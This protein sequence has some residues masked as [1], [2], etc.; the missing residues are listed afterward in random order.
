[1]GEMTALGSDPVFFSRDRPEAYLTAVATNQK[2]IRLHLSGHHLR[3][4]DKAALFA[5]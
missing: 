2:T 1:M 3:Q 4:P 5:Q